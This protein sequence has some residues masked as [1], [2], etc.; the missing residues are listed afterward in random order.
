MEQETQYTDIEMIE[1]NT[2]SSVQ[3]LGGDKTITSNYTNRLGRNVKL[4]RGDK[5]S[6]SYSFIN[7]RGCG[8]PDAIEINGIQTG[9]EEI[10]IPYTDVENFGKMAVNQREKTD[11]TEY[12][13]VALKEY[14]FFP[15]DDEINVPINYYCN[16]NGEGYYFL[17]RR[18]LPPQPR[19][20]Y[21]TAAGQTDKA[22]EFQRNITSELWTTN[23]SVAGGRCFYERGEGSDVY[24]MCS[25]DMLFFYDS[26]E[27]KLG[28]FKPRTD[29]GKLTILVKD[30]MVQNYQ[31]NTE[32]T[33]FW[34]H[35]KTDPAL[36]TF[37]LYQE[38]LNLKLPKG[39]NSPENIADRL[40]EQIQEERPIVELDIEDGGQ[41]ARDQIY[42]RIYS[43]KTYKPFNSAGFLTNQKKG[44]DDFMASS[45]SLQAQ[46]YDGSYQYI[47]CNRPDLFLVGREFQSYTEHH[48]INNAITK[49]ASGGPVL[50]TAIN[51]SILYTQDNLIKLSKIF[52]IQALYPELFQGPPSMFGGTIDAPDVT[53]DNARF[54]HINRYK[55]ATGDIG[56]ELG[57]DNYVDKGANRSS[58]PIFFKYDKSNEDRFTSGDDFQDLSYGFATRYKNGNQYYIALRPDLIGGIQNYIFE[59]D[60]N[61]TAGTRQIGWDWHFSAYGIVCCQLYSGYTEY[62]YDDTEGFILASKT[63]NT[64]DN[65]N[66]YQ[67]GVNL[68]PLVTQTYL[69]CNNGAVI[70]N[71]DGHFA[72]TQLHT[73]ENVGQN[74]NAGDDN[75]PDSSSYNPIVAT[76]GD[77]AYKINKQ[78][79]FWS[80][81]PEMKPY[82]SP[83]G[84][85]GLGIIAGALATSEIWV[86][87]AITTPAFWT[88]VV[89]NNTEKLP[90]FGKVNYDK[91]NNAIVPYS[92]IDSQTGIILNLNQSITEDT[93]NDSLLGILGFS[94]EQIN[95]DVI[96]SSNNIL[97]RVSTKNQNKLRYITTNSVIVSTET[98]DFV[99]NRYGAVQ[100]TNQITI[101]IGY[102]GWVNGK[103]IGNT[104]N[105]NDLRIGGGQAVRESAYT[106]FPVIVQQTNS[107]NIS[108]ELLPRRMIN[109]YY[110]IR[111]DLLLGGN[112][113]IG[114]R[115]GNS[116][117]PIID[118]VNKE[119]G[120][121]DY[122]FSGDS[123]EITITNE[124]NISEITTQITNPDGKFSKIDNGSCVI[125][126]I[127]RSK[128]LDNT[129][130]EQILQANQPKKSKK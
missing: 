58:M 101:P 92:I 70:Y 20:V 30:K 57:Y 69:G 40:T 15:R 23:D 65:E 77:S 24:S 108:G 119:N 129:I 8:I 99:V 130:I 52:K 124:M 29:G 97:S 126:K 66:R 110:C 94:W 79:N 91:L 87:G 39:Y 18:F 10:S 84:S 62:M 2:R 12:S 63:F 116:I 102:E 47:G 75:D 90:N 44:F 16:T 103:P 111:S 125:Y 114:G 93:I 14:K 85:E 35:L 122:F 64:T 86:D 31:Y 78:L 117:L 46:N 74:Y 33:T 45:N 109:P 56:G 27:G 59:F 4:K 73:A 9:D 104:T 19:M 118:I 106:Q 98:K 80:W 81:T 3:Y 54:L 22:L 38:V 113:F 36:Q 28:Y 76:A 61:I 42:S 112:N 89:N 32:S 67:K 1:C 34:N 107:I 68:A 55:E 7:E 60:G 115:D 72:F 51:T 96:D 6:V 95:P 53:L 100:Y 121:G 17:P 13:S 120:D 26:E 128:I 88:I 41:P 48:F 105:E 71:E 83:N 5:V 82:G 127:Q 49:D 50:G 25:S 21:S 123:R 11:T 37:H 43:T